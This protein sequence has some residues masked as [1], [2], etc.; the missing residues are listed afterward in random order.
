MEENNRAEN[1][2]KETKEEEKIQESLKQ[3]LLFEGTN[4]ICKSLGR[5]NM[6]LGK[7]GTKN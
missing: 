5:L 4:K 7:E 2:K 1:N 3:S 6:M